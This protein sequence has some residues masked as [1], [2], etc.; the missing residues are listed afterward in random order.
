MP[1]RNEEIVMRDILSFSQCLEDL[2]GKDIPKSLALL[3]SDITMINERASGFEKRFG[4]NN[5]VSTRSLELIF[6]RR[7]NRWRLFNET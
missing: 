2:Q 3:K 4:F 7:Y 6:T 5:E 1:S